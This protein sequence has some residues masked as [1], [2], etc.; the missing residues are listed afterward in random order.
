MANGHWPEQSGNLVAPGNVDITC[1]ETSSKQ[2]VAVLVTHVTLGRILRNR[3]TVPYRYC[4]T[5]YRALS[6]PGSGGGF[7]GQTRGDMGLLFVRDA[8]IRYGT[9][10]LRWSHCHR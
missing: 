5:A 9:V 7:P 6:V 3:R 1:F 10:R 4:I 8:I 2:R